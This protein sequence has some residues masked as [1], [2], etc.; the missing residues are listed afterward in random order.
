MRRTRPR[1]ER[2]KNGY[3]II[4]AT[5][6]NDYNN[7]LPAIRKLYFSYSESAI[8]FVRN[9]RRDVLQIEDESFFFKIVFSV[10]S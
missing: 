2:A 5:F 4:T 6:K 9:T 8:V 7:G 1:R 3:T 10:I